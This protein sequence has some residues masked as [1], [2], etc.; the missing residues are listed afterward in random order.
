[1]TFNGWTWRRIG[2][3]LAGVAVC[4]GAY[5]FFESQKQK[6]IR[7]AK[8][9]AQGEVLESLR[10]KAADDVCNRSV[11]RELAGRLESLDQIGEAADALERAVSNC[12][13]NIGMTEWLAQLYQRHGDL[14]RALE[15][16]QVIVERRPTLAVG[17]AVR[18][19]IRRDLG[20][21]TLALADYEQVFALESGNVEAGRVLADALE[22]RGEPCQAAMVL[23]QMLAFSDPDDGT[24]LDARSGRLRTLGNC[25]RERIKDGKATIPVTLDS[26]VMLVRLRINGRIDATMVLD[27][28]ASSVALTSRLAGRLGLS[29]DRAQAYYVG[30]ANGAALAY[31]VLLENVK[32]GGA[33]VSGVAGAIVPQLDL[34]PDI[35]GLLGNSFLSH[36]R[37]RVDASKRQVVLETLE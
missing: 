10:E 27:T 29:P 1:V 33:Q 24:W 36:F 5:Q 31:R 35:D 28:G 22:E 32:L 18:G 16:A 9:G 23:D 21:S 7:A 17:Y 11:A 34:G 13:F 8:Y 6:N 4:F 37:V 2:G 12:P 25:P 26:D 15:V 30:T 20:L 3:V 19:S 14:A